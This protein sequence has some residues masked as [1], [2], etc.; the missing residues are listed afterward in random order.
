MKA[1]VYRRD[2]QR[3]IF[4]GQLVTEA[5]ACAHVINRSQGGLGIE[6]NII[7]VCPDCHRELDNGRMTTLLRETA[8]NYMKTMYEGWNREKVTYRKGER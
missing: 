5:D 3:C 8:I 6:E 4:C 1:K 7:T 2:G